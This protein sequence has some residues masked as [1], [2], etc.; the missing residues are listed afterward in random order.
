MQV[1]DIMTIDPACCTPDLSLQEAAQLM[2]DRDCGEIPIIEQRRI[3]GVVTD[4]DIACRAVAKG[5]VPATTQVRE[6]MSAP[7][8]VVAV[9]A[10]VDECCRLMETAQVRR[11]PVVD[12]SNQCCGIVSQAD[13]A[14][15]ASKEKAG[16]VVRDI[17]RPAANAL[18]TL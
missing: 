11:I 10:D 7:V 4:R 14:R 18:Q 3:V 2:A 5:K 8:V 12:E 13:I 16:E 15:S 1:R 17:S 9:D 6:I